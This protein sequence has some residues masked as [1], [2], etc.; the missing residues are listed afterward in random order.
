VYYKDSDA[1]DVKDLS[2]EEETPEWSQESKTEEN[3]TQWEKDESA[4]KSPTQD[5][6][7]ASRK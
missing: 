4:K 3:K 7:K 5:E 2:Y 1:Y 6:R